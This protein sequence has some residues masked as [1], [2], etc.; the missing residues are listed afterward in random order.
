MVATNVGGMGEIFGPFRH[1]LI[2]CNEV[3]ILADAMES[4]VNKEPATLRAEAGE[5]ADFVATN[6]TVAG[7]AEAVILGYREAMAARLGQVYRSPAPAAP[8][9]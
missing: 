4:A 8:A 3:N 7:M 9:T 5:L 6:F 1:R 2:P